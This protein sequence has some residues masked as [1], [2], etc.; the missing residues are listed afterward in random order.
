MLMRRGKE[1]ARRPIHEMRTSRIICAGGLDSHAQPRYTRTAQHS[2][3][4][5]STAQHSTAQANCALFAPCGCWAL[6][7]EYNICDKNVHRT[8][9]LHA[10]ARDG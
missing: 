4:Q 1:S 10:K 6:E 3:A 5:H 7:T 2:T 9:L 8:F